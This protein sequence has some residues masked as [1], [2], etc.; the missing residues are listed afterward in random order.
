M[1]P[2][3][4]TARLSLSA[5]LMSARVVKKFSFTT[6]WAAKVK[7]PMSPSVP[8]TIPPLGRG[9]KGK[10]FWAAGSTPPGTGVGVQ[11]DAS[12]AEQRVPLRAAGDGTVDSLVIPFDWRIPS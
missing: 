9:Q 3:Y 11:D 6:C 2:R 8:G 5:I 12:G 1:S 7:I 4:V 10:Y